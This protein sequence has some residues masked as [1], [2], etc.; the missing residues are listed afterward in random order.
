[1]IQALLNFQEDAAFELVRE[2]RTCESLDAVAARI[3]AKEHGF[4]VDD[5]EDE[6]QP[7]TNGVSQTSTFETQ[8]W[9]KMGDLRLDDGSVRYIGGTSN[10]IH[11]NQDDDIDEADEYPQQEVSSK[12]L[13]TFHIL[14][15][16]IS[17]W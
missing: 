9:G 15:M 1:M 7:I 3:V 16:A 13:A 10:L 2:I 17:C 6:G 4:D 8:L 12:R 14:L 11:I 5:E